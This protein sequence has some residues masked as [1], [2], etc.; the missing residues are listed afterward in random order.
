MIEMTE[1]KRIFWNVLATYGRSLYSLACGLLTGRWVLLALGAEDYGLF[2]VVGGLTAFIAFFNNILASSIGRFYTFSIGRA[3]IVES[4]KEGLNECQ[5]W[6]NTAVSIHTVVPLVLILLGYP[7]GVWAIKSFLTIPPDRVVSCI[8]VFRFACA[9]CFVA[10]MNVPFQAMFTAK[11][12]IAELTIYSFVTTTLNVGFLYYL[13]THPGIWLTKYAAWT[14]AMTAVPQ[15]IICLRAIRIFPE[16]K[17]NMHMWFSIE[18]F[19]RLGAFAAWQMIGAFS[20]LLRGQGIAILI[21]KFHGATVNAAMSV[22]NTLNGQAFTLSSAM[23]GAFSPAITTA[24]G[25]RDMDRMQTLAFSACKFGVMLSLLFVIP[26]IIELPAV[27]KIW[28]KTPPPYVSGITAL[29]LIS[30]VIENSTYGHQVAV[31]ASGQIAV[32]QVLMGMVSLLALP[33]A[34]IWAFSGGTP[35][36]AI[37]S[38]IITQILYTIL[39][40]LLAKKITGLPIQPWI[41]QIMI[42]LVL[43]IL[44]C[45][46]M[47]TLP[48]WL[49]A[50]SLGRIVLSSIC[51]MVVFIPMAWWI[52]MNNDERMF[53][54][55]KLK[56]ILC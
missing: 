48:R 44:G 39:R 8:W 55:S 53:V 33:V 56:K 3:K 52:V 25:A 18:R 54:V 40:V 26:L 15:F 38:I 49:M 29:L 43:L 36:T 14:C 51:C 6:F 2:G 50:E 46:L 28:L 27:L 4:Q 45:C 41:V 1:N 13:V 22:G 24:Y 42:P 16:C 21:N 7:I 35:N 19:E 23:M 30:H 12:Y 17:L 9:A 32:Y 5:A 31:S 11:Q 47:G 10:M 34:T 20:A 37:L